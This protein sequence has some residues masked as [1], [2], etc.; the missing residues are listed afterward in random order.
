[1]I[2]PIESQVSHHL[3]LLR[4]ERRFR[5]RRSLINRISRRRLSPKRMSSFIEG[6]YS[7]KQESLSGFVVLG[8]KEPKRLYFIF[9]PD[10]CGV[11]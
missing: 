5:T 2:I 1:V 11:S 8:T 3:P 10:A 4:Y 7:V 6:F 9:S